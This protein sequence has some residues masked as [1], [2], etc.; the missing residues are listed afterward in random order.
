M[1]SRHKGFTLIEILVVIVIFSIIVAATYQALFTGNSLWFQTETKIKL[2]ENLRLSIDR[3]IREVQQSGIDK[4]GISQIF[5]LN[6]EG[7]NSSDVLRFSIPIVCEVNGNVMGNDGYVAHWGAPL[8][9]GCHAPTCMDADNNCNTI[10]YKYLEY[11]L[12]KDSKLLRRV[13]DYNWQVIREDVIAQHIMDFQV[14]QSFDQRIVS[15]H[16][17]AEEVSN[18]KAPFSVEADFDV[19]LRNI[20]GRK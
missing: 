4:K 7:F 1:D 6:G 19:Y 9:W 12:S 15:I 5:I 2:R 13:L 18:S 20:E 17:T 8:T 14:E 16:V 3:L 10:D 11:R